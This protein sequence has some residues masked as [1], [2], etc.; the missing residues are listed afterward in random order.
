[1]DKTLEEGGNF[2]E[3]NKKGFGCPASGS[4]DDIRGEPMLR[5]C[6]GTPC[7][8]GLAAKVLFEEKAQVGDE[9]GE[10]GNRHEPEG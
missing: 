9:K 5:K 4:L 8:H 2:T 10:G 3:V 7:S 6:S 1:V